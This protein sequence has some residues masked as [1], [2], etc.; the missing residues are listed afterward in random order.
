MRP[1]DAPAGPVA[2]GSNSGGPRRVLVAVGTR[3]E[4]VK[5]APVVRELHRSDRWTPVL[6]TTG[7]HGTVVDEV[8]ATFA[9]KPDVRLPAWRRNGDLAGLYAELIPRLAETLER[10]DPAA[11]IVQGDTAT[12]L[13]GAMTAFWARVPVLHLE[14]G[15]RTGDLSAPFPEEANRR[16]VGQITA[17]HLPPTEGAAAA[18]LSEGVDPASMLVVGNTVVDAVRWLAARSDRRPLPDRYSAAPGR[19]SLLVTC[20]RRENWGEGTR[21]VAAA[22]RRLVAEHSSLDVVVAAHPNPQVREVLDTELSSLAAVTVRDAIPYDEFVS[23]LDR[24][25]LVLTD[26]GGV[27]EE[28]A[29]LGVPALVAREVT[30]RHEGVDAGLAELVGTD[31]EVIVASARRLLRRVTTGRTPNGSCPYG[32]GDAA[33]RTVGALAHVLDNCPLPTPFRFPASGGSTRRPTSL[34]A[35][36][37]SPR[38]SRSRRSISE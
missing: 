29:A 20:H 4:A 2:G 15:L 24:S 23:L 14:A 27:Q 31:P 8:L 30:E 25:D 36:M 5:L 37:V 19:T 6:V 28:A 34:P 1:V 18:L 38:V 7:Q 32:D 33:E 35:H 17:F 13:A 12:T 10:V 11:V 9:T 16:M 3:P 21:R 26:S 22:L